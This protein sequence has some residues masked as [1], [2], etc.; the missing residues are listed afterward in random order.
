MVGDVRRQGLSS[1]P[2]PV[3]Y[4]PIRSS[5]VR[6]ASFVLR[7][8]R[9]TDAGREALE[10][11]LRGAMRAVAPTVAVGELGTMEESVAGSLSQHRF[12]AQFLAAF[13]ALTLLLTAVGL[14]GLTSYS[15]RRGRHLFGVKMASPRRWSRFLLLVAEALLLTL[16]GL[17]SGLIV[18]SGLVRLL[19]SLLFGVTVFDP[20]TFLGAPVILGPV[21]LAAIL[22]GARHKSV[23]SS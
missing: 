15:A 16:A 17:A 18:A 5:P 9:S 21:V 20:I 3:V 14:H 6:G 1:E 11:K 10:A 19:A 4:L 8:T 12:T 7:T 2:E 13:A 22:T 23:E